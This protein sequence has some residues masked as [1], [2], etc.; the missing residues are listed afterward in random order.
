MDTFIYYLPFW[1]QTEKKQARICE[2]FTLILFL[3][4]SK[5]KFPSRE[6]DRYSTM[7]F[8]PG[9]NQ[10]STSS[11]NCGNNQNQIETCVVFICEHNGMYEKWVPP[12]LDFDIPREH[13][14][15]SFPLC[16]DCTCQVLWTL[17][18][19]E[20]IHVFRLSPSLK[21][22]YSTTLAS[23]RKKRKRTK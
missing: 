16:E 12:K 21:F 14:R 4:T 1:R 2:D 11:T 17:S 13:N 19:S 3:L 15:L 9:G 20:V 7:E 18:A 10:N 8:F 5:S 6:A 23:C 22:A